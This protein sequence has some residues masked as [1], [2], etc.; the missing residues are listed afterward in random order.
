MKESNNWDRKYQNKENI[1]K[2]PE[3]F[4]VQNYNTLKEG[5][6]LDFA[7][8][9]GRN[10]IFIAKKGFQVTAV[11]FSNEALKRL[12]YFTSKE[13]INVN[14]LCLD[15]S[16]NKSISS[17]DTFDNIII[18]CYKLEDFLIEY[19]ENLLNPSGIL[20]YCTFNINHHIENAFKKSLCL[21]PSELL[22][23]FSLNLLKY[24]SLNVNNRYIDGYIFKK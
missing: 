13:N 11:D 3:D 16:N 17:L 24:E 15:L 6:V 2:N 9:D 7:S 18:C 14:T 12:I 10:S 22:H 5:T 23:K 8:G 19:I 20:I 1:L 4:I 21:E